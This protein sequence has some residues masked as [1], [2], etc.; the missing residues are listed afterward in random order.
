V[1]VLQVFRRGQLRWLAW[2][3]LGHSLVDFT[4]VLLQ[5]LLGPGLNSTLIVEAVVCVYGV[6]AIWIIWRLRDEPLSA[7]ATDVLCSRPTPMTGESGHAR[8][9]GSG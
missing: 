1:V 8:S 9:G 3:I 5:Q 2:A 4:A 7:P 6:I